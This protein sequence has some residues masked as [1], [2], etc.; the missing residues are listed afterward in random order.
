[1][2]HPSIS[3]HDFGVAPDVGPTKL[4]TLRQKSGATVTLTDYGATWVGWSTPDRDGKFA[5]VVLGF[6][7][8]AS[9]AKHTGFFGAT[10]GRVANR[11]AA[12]KFR[13]E[14]KTYKLAVNN[15]PNHLHGGKIGFDRHLWTAT[16]G[17]LPEE[18]SVTFSRRS[19]DGEEGYPGNLDIAVTYTFLPDDSVRIDYRASTDAPTIVNLTNHAYFNLGG[20]AH[21]TVHDHR[22]KLNAALYL[23]KDNAITIPTGEIASVAGTPFDFRESRVLGAHIGDTHPQMVA[24]RGYDTSF[25]VDGAPDELRPCATLSHP[26]SGR[27]LEVETTEPGVHLYTGNWV[28]ECA[29]EVPGKAGAIYGHQSGL[30]L[31]TQGF[32]D[33]INHAGF[34]SVIL[35]P[36]EIH[37]SSSV[38]RMRQGGV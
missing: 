8:A 31:E 16:C 9:Y 28:K 23:P 13:L 27:I 36:G 20:H 12:G 10:C 15:G 35:R 17:G 2:Q 29:G 33:A 19:P 6:E 14:G 1:M 26:A 21:G 18:P 11:I 37:A 22:V 38:F 7:N 32:P 4:F 3:I 25:V 5:D 34:P 30:C 24:D